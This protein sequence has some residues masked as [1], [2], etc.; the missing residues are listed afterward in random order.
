MDLVQAGKRVLMRLIVLL[1]ATTTQILPGSSMVSHG[2]TFGL[3]LSNGIPDLGIW[4]E[5][6]SVLALAYFISFVVTTSRRTLPLHDR[7]ARTE[8]VWSA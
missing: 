2:V 4:S 5:V 3:T 8:A 7:W 1:P 6:L